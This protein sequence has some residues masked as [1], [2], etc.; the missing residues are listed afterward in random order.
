MR[1]LC[2]ILASLLVAMPAKAGPKVI[3][4]IMPVHAIVSAVMGQ[5]GSPDLLLSGRLSEHRAAFTPSQVAAL[6]EADL[7]FIVGP[8]L[9]AKLAQMSGGEA[10]NG[11]MFVMLAEMPGVDRLAVREGGSWDDHDHAAETGSGPEPGA[12]V[13]AYD[14]HVWLD[15]DNAKAMA[16]G[17]AAALA[18]ADPAHAGDYQV[19]AEAFAVAVD[20]VAGEIA[21]ELTPV[22]DKPFI[23][24]HDAYQYFERHFGLN[25]VGSITDVSARAAS[26]ERL[27]AIRDRLA[28]SHAV[29]VF[30]EPQYD[31]RVVDTVV[32]GSDVRSGILDPVGA[33][34]AP[35]P[36]A[37]VELLRNLAA[38]FRSCLAG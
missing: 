29:C 6:A 23:V 17:A 8:G 11:K 14:P 16:R 30:R 7:V 13:L 3:A 28:Q 20:N 12:G 22:R 5:Q 21:G 4:S 27:K 37:Y 18:K 10:V 25:G 36:G 33:E 1:R 15:P 35:G 9:E 19:N 26:A 38:A 24:F 31:S 32:E 2:L 34:L